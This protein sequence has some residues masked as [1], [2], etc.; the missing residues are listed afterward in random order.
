VLGG[1]EGHVDDSHGLLQARMAGGDGEEIA[2]PG[3]E[4]GR[5]TSAPARKSSNLPVCSSSRSRTC[6]MCSRELSRATLHR[7]VKEHRVSST[8][9]LHAISA[10]AQARAEAV[11]AVSGGLHEPVQVMPR[12]DADL[13]VA[14]E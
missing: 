3:V 11:H 6:R 13:Q 4:A 1:E 12:S 7:R 5:K 10:P 14:L 9:A 2:I 8:G